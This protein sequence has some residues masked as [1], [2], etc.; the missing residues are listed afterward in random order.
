[1]ESK[2]HQ[3]ASIVGLSIC[4]SL[5]QQLARRPCRAA[6][7]YCPLEQLTIGGPEKSGSALR[8]KPAMSGQMVSRQT[9][10]LYFWNSKSAISAYDVGG[11]R[12]LKAMISSSYG[13][14][15]D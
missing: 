8:Q 7:S 10:S 13:I 5:G 3:D 12:C 1:M 14:K 2:S 6:P 15:A 4:P 9:L 11:L